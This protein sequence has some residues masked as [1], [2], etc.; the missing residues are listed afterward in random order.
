MLVLMDEDAADDDHILSTKIYVLDNGDEHDD[1][2]D[3][4]DKDDV[5]VP[6]IVG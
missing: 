1:D 4:E 3:D 6:F 2:E 5:I